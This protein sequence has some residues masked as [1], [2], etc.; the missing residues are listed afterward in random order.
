MRNKNYTAR[1]ALLTL[2]T[3]FFNVPAAAAVISP[4]ACSTFTDN[5]SHIVIIDVGEIATPIAAPIVPTGKCAKADFDGDGKLDFLVQGAA[6]GDEMFLFRADVNGKYTSIAQRWSNDFLGLS[7]TSNSATT[8]IDDFNGDGRADLLIQENGASPT[9][10]LVYSDADGRFT[11]LTETWSLVYRVETKTTVAGA[12]VGSFNVNSR[13][14]VEYSIPLAVPPGRAGM[15]PQLALSYSSGGGDG[16]L[17]LGWSISGLS[18]ISRCPATTAQDSFKGGINFD[19]ND[20]FCFD[21]QRLIAVSGVD[22]A[23]GTEYRTEVESFTRVKSYSKAGNGPAYFTAETKAGLTM[24]FGKDPSASGTD[25]VGRI[26]ASG[27]ADVLVWAVTR[28]ED[29]LGNAIR[30]Q[31]Y[32]NNTTGEYYPERIE[33]TGRGNQGFDRLV[34]FEYDALAENQR[35]ERYVAGSKISRSTRVKAIKTYLFNPDTASFSTL[36]REYKPEY[37][38]YTSFVDGKLR[39]IGFQEC[40]P[41]KCFEPTSFGWQGTPLTGW[42]MTPDTVQDFTFTNYGDWKTGDIDGDGV[43]DI[44]VQRTDISQTD[45]VHRYKDGTT[46]DPHKLYV[47]LNQWEVAD[48][49]GD[50]L[51]D[52]LNVR[53]GQNATVVRFNT[54]ETLD[55]SIDSGVPLGGAEVFKLGDFNGD[56]LPDVIRSNTS[57]K[58][59]TIWINGGY[60]NFSLWI[61]PNINLVTNP[62]E[63]GQTYTG[64]VDW[65]LADVNADGRSDI[66]RFVEDSVQGKSYVDVTRFD[67]SGAMVTTQLADLTALSRFSEVW[68]DSQPIWAVQ[69]RVG[70]RIGDFNGD[71]VAD[72]AVAGNDNLVRVFVGNGL[73][74]VARTWM[75]SAPIWGSENWQLAD[76]NQD[77]ITDIAKRDASTGQ[78]KLWLFNGYSAGTTAALTEL[79]WSVPIPSASTWQINDY[80]GDGLLDISTIANDVFTTYA[81]PAAKPLLVN[82]IR[83][84]YGNTTTIDYAPLTDPAVYS[85]SSVRSPYAGLSKLTGPMY[86]VKSYTAPDGVGGSHTLT[87]SYSTGRV[88]RAGRGF[89]GFDSVT[90][91][92]SSLNSRTT[93]SF[94]I[95]TTD[96]PAGDYWKS[97]LVKSVDRVQA[98][99]RLSYLTTTW[100]A[101]NSDAGRPNVFASNSTETA[102]DADAV[103][104]TQL[105]TTVTVINAADVDTYGNVK[106]I[107]ITTTDKTKSTDNVYTKVTVSEYDAANVSRWILGRLNKVTVT[108]TVPNLITA[109]TG[110]TDPD[111]RVS[112]FT[113]Y[114]TNSPFVGMLQEERIQPLAGGNIEIA[115]SYGYDQYG[116]RVS[117]T[118]TGADI[119]TRTTSTTY[120]PDGYFP[121]AA[122]NALGQS[123]TVVYD[124]RFGVATSS[125]G[126]NGISTFWYYDEMGRKIREERAD[127]T[128]TVWGY[129]PASDAKFPSEKY[130]VTVQS[131]GAPPST[132]YYDMLGRA[133][134]ADT[135]DFLGYVVRSLTR[136]DNLSRVYAVSEPYHITGPDAVPGADTGSPQNVWTCSRY[137]AFGRLVEESLP[138]RTLC[139]AGASAS[140]VARTIAY[141]GYVTTVTV[142]NQEVNNGAITTQKVTTTTDPRGKTVKVLDALNN[143]NAYL[144]DASGNLVRTEFHDKSGDVAKTTTVAMNYDIRGR[145]VSMLD[146]DMGTWT[147]EYN[148]AGELIKQTDATNNVVTMT[149]DILGRLRTRSSTSEGTT[150]WTYDTA[151]K[152]VGK[153]ARIDNPNTG[154]SRLMSYD[155]LGRPNAVTSTIDG[156]SYNVSNSYDALGR[157]DTV[158][159]PETG[160]TYGRFNV[161]NVYNNYGYLIRVENAA[162]NFVYWQLNAQDALGHVTSEF[163]AGS[164]YLVN[165]DYENGDGGNPWRRLRQAYASAGATPL[166]NLNFQ[167]DWLG[168][169]SERRDERVAGSPLKETFL[170]DGLNRLTKTTLSNATLTNVV[171]GTYTYDNNGNLTKKS[172]F[173]ATY[174]YDPVKVHAVKTVKN[175]SGGVVG[176]YGYDDAGR[177]T[178]QNGSAIVYTSFGQPQTITKDGK[179]TTFKYNP[180]LM[181]MVQDN[182]D[183]VLTYLD[184][185]PANGG[186]L[187][188]KEYVRATF[189]TVHRHFI[190]APTGRIAEYEVSVK[191]TTVTASTNYFLTDHLG[192]IDAVLPSSGVVADIKRTSFDAFGKRRSAGDWKSAGTALAATNLGYTGHEQL[193]HL[194]LV[195][196][197]GRL[198]DPALGRFTSADPNI[199]GAG[200]TQGF[201]RYSYVHNN[202]LNATDPSGYLSVFKRLMNAGQYYSGQDA[203]NKYVKNHEWAQQVVIAVASFYLGPWGT[204]L[205]TGYVTSLYTNDPT[206]ILTSAFIAGVT[207]AMAGDIAKQA[208][209]LSFGDRAASVLAQGV[210][211]GASAAAGGGDFNAGFRSAMVLQAFAPIQGGLKAATSAGA[212]AIRIMMAALAGGTTAALGGGKFKNGAGTFAFLTY[213]GEAADYYQKGVGRLADPLPGENREN[214]SLYVPDDMGRQRPEDQRMNVIA[215]NREMDGSWKDY[216]T[217]GGL[218]SRVLNVIPMINATAGLHDFWFNEG[219]PNKLPFTL[220]TNVGTMLPAAVVTMGAAV[221]RVTNGWDRNAVTMRNLALHQRV[222]E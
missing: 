37:N 191:G 211:G 19:A 133:V 118:F 15:T 164:K 45:I 157:V 174:E 180:D 16:L 137:D 222:E 28:I 96:G 135:L 144:Y 166:Q 194:G 93:T 216:V 36:V 173:G 49:N 168:N 134:R 52:I 60:G 213:F 139:T 206:A 196:M 119:T 160:T 199:D 158:T 210:V 128:S 38:T 195:H 17:G 78:L 90:E 149:Y 53:P 217:Q 92:N 81:M 68:V 94:F 46:S 44:L 105:S 162:S 124:P 107:T 30:F 69:V 101:K 112:S 193:D 74:G 201:N 183:R 40:G 18:M 182:T 114:G 198:Y 80:N 35:A 84:A 27:R 177:M 207:S 120:S 11:T 190:S 172:T 132:T 188:E 58:A 76:F 150:T 95:Q 187:Y 48:F 26:E 171:T 103:V 122:T 167:W 31:Y 33:Y 215:L 131:S 161:R 102:Y 156:V 97:G 3:A 125:T 192:S 184:P 147:Y 129:A 8:Y 56:G 116:N 14:Q 42:N 57:T 10:S 115:T 175:A 75:L 200:S 127:G 62:P 202:P 34:L 5:L 61:N 152:G 140:A 39:L 104:S 2:T 113:Y 141:S 4:A 208:G 12:T 51:A 203:I 23:A 117:A 79:V 106:K 22:G 20:R 111:T 123:E 154:Y 41:T 83:Q 185:S 143:Y 130:S 6:S 55:G 169:L 29:K 126:P 13:G 67:T 47:G 146:P 186:H 99:K 148:A 50:G 70:M 91:T 209:G 43:T 155:A 121:V 179:V 163:L 1:L 197:N 181:R 219:N 7:W 212:G 66:V 138:E 98:D 72:V 24:Y 86:V 32:E 159:Y 110:D 63:L 108:D 109:A 165:R 142:N 65:Q 145:K 87:R 178:N 88:H 151:E 170:Y 100:S 204:A 77:G 176:S 189:T 21:G 89:I 214:Q 59:T 153:L 82:S 136:Y 25:S 221:G 9:L 71:G 64:T 220:I 218:L 73:A 85:L 54:D 205:A